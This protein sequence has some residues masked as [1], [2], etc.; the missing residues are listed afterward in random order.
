M[1]HQRL[2][3]YL[4]QEGHHVPALFGDKERT[5]GLRLD[6]GPDVLAKAFDDLR[7][8]HPYQNACQRLRK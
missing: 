7:V 2:G 3:S 5:Q 4:R 1:Q 8:I 6:T